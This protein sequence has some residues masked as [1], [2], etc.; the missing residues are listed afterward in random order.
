MDMGKKIKIPTTCTFCQ[1]EFQA[2]KYLIK[3]TGN[4]CSIQCHVD[5]QR[6]SSK[7]K[8]NRDIIDGKI[9]DRCKEHLPISK[10]RKYPRGLYYN[11]CI[12]CERNRKREYY[13]LNKDRILKRETIR[14]KTPESKIRRR[15]LFIEYNNNN[16]QKAWGKKALRRHIKK[17][18]LVF[19]TH[20]EITTL[21]NNT[22]NCPICGVKFN[23]N[24]NENR[25]YDEMPSLD[26][27]NNEPH[28]NRGN[29]MIICL[30]C[31]TTKGNRTLK[32]MNYWCQQFLKFSEEKKD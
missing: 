8:N 17:G 28:I 32:E 24:S 22:T 31:N 18:H 25:K 14:K 19:L 12:V 11:I 7:E 16:P 13:L 15:T 20:D 5:Y 27:I 2:N 6:A 26:R 30:K 1:K 10:F 4:F 29:A 21:A 3:N 23:Y 9:C